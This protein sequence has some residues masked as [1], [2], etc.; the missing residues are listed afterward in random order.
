MRIVLLAAAGL[1]ALPALLL[2]FK[3][4]PMPNVAGGFGEPTCR[5]CHL[6]NPLNAPGGALTISG[7]PDAYQPG[8]RYVV[9]V[10][11]R[12]DEMRRGG[13]EMGARFAS[14]N[15]KGR[16][17]G[18]WRPLDARVQLQDSKDHSV[19]FAQHTIAGTRAASRGNLTWR[20]EWMAPPTASGP[21]QFNAAANASNDDASPLGDYIYASEIRSSPR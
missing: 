14:G 1:V 4:G 9:V 11:L 7:V 2:A 5:M 10:H 15:A 17:A 16:Q 21:V 12:R 6:D 13:F 20:F 8:R 19:Q 18:V 3:E